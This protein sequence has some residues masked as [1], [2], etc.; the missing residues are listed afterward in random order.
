[1]Q[2]KIVALVLDNSVSRFFYEHKSKLK[3]DSSSELLLCFHFAMHQQQ[4]RNTN[5]NA[6]L[7]GNITVEYST[8]SETA[9]DAFV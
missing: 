4:D 8:S 2:K 9:L 5:E 3:G 7:C 1:M 6:I